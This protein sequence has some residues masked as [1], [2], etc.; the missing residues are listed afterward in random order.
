MRIFRVNLVRRAAM[1][2]KEKAKQV[3][4]EEKGNWIYVLRFIN[5]FLDLL[6]LPV[7]QAKMDNIQMPVLPDLPVHPDHLELPVSP[8][9]MDNLAKYLNQSIL[10]TSLARCCWPTWQRCRLLSLPTSY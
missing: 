6:V 5:N 2:P 8:E 4:P 3:Q 9:K 7:V 10:Y 1:V